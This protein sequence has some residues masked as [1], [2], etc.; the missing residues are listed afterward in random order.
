MLFGADKGVSF[1]VLDL[2][3]DMLGEMDEPCTLSSGCEVR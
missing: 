1:L 3:G 2:D